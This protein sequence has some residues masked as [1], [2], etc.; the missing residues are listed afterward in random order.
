MAKNEEIQKQIEKL[1]P[2]KRALLE[3]MLRQREQTRESKQA[4]PRR[5]D[6]AQVPLSYVQQRLWVLDQLQPGNPA[7]N[8]AVP[9]RIRGQYQTGA[10]SHSL[11]QLIQRHEILRTVFDLID[12]QPVQIIHQA[13]EVPLAEKDLSHLPPDAREAEAIRLAG[14]ESKRPFNLKD[15]PLM[16]TLLLRLDHDDHL[17]L[18][19]MHHIISDDWSMGI[20]IQ[21][22]SQIYEAKARGETAELSELPIQYGDFAHWQR[23]QFQGALLEKQLAYWQEQLTVSNDGQRRLPVLQMPTDRPRPSKQTF[24]G[25]KEPVNLPADLSRQLNQLRQ[26]ENV[27]LFMIL[28]AAFQTLLHRYTEQ[29]DLIVGMPIAGRRQSETEGLI[30]YFVNTLALRTDLSG[31]PTF[32]ELLQRVR[33]VVLGA[34]DNQDLPVEKII[35][36]LQPERDLSRP[37]LFQTMLILRTAPKPALS[38]PGLEIEPVDAVAHTAPVDLTLSLTD[39]P[40]G[41]VGSLEYNTD[42]FDPS[43]MQRFLSHFQVLLE[44]IV[45]NPDRRLSTLPLLSSLETQQ[46]LHEWNPATPFLWPGT[47][48]HQR[49]TKQARRAPNKIAVAGDQKSLTYAELNARSNQLAHYLQGLGVKPEITVGLYIP[50][51]VDQSVAMLGVLKAGGAYVPLDPAYPEERLAFMLENANIS[52][53]L[54]Q[55]AVIA[56]ADW[57][58]QSPQ[59]LKIVCLDSEWHLINQEAADE[60]QAM[61]HPDNLAYIIY[62]SG[63]TGQPKG[64][65]VTHRSLMAYLTAILPPLDIQ[66]EDRVLNFASISFDATTEELYPVWFNGATVVLRPERIAPHLEFSEFVAQQRISVLSLPAP[67]WHEWVYQLSLLAAESPKLPSHVRLILLNAAEPAP[68]R[69]ALWRKFGGDDVRWINTYG[70]TE[71]T[72]TATIYEPTTLGEKEK[73]WPR[74]PIGRPLVNCTLYVLDTNMKPVPT[75]VP[76]R[77]YI[78]GSGVTRGYLK[79][80]SLTAERFIPDPFSQLGGA[81]FYDTGDL[82]RY[83]S[84]GNLE[85]LGRVDHQV[86]VRGFRVEPGEIE[87]ILAQHPALQENA[88]QAWPDAGGNNQLV[89]YVVYG[90]GQNVSFSDLRH[91]LSEKLPGY[92]VPTAFEV[93]LTLPRLPNGKVDRDRLPKPAPDRTQQKPDYVA[94]RTDLEEVLASIFA[95]TLNIDE[96]GIFDDFFERGG[97]SLIA[98]Q[99]ISRIH[100]IF[101]IQ[102]PLRALFES[103]TV[104][105]LTTTLMTLP[106]HGRNIETTAKMLIRLSQLPNEA[107]KKMLVEKKADNL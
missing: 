17:L 103:P 19:C 82:V 54:T 44:G 2:Q 14:E 37:L 77:L 62:T 94:P 65:S 68:D 40:K 95:E 90:P 85:F 23:Q 51:S 50:R 13:L 91:F 28:L 70:P 78:G 80:P 97:H 25:S 27:T 106:A 84:D 104:A 34:L 33:P 9:L 20:F 87:A 39:T 22:M 98:T 102:L 83:L 48:A 105:G 41:L 6:Q 1:S 99:V 76:G 101:K 61:L 60:P 38:L 35:E 81:R 69:F 11:E 64:V 96:I 16:R 10:L 56:A 88:V 8:L 66:P 59:P 71:I 89:A 42:L 93:L 107:V 86:K 5:P 18:I 12:D 36:L 52:V 73:Q 100:R 53:L 45:A 32:R 58:Y 43:T 79:R 75:G 26:Q 29:N 67:F 24:V 4:I 3:A 15:G 63:S 31:D 55:E 72:V 74:M 49:F 46:L 57:Q 92:M 30:G 47:Y 21:E 7:Y